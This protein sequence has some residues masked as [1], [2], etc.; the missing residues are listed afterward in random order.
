[1]LVKEDLGGP[2]NK[3]RVQFEQL[4]DFSRKPSFVSPQLRDANRAV[5]PRGKLRR[6]WDLPDA[7]GYQVAKRI[8]NASAS[9]QT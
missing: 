7:V 5:V 8:L 9:R 2:A 1:M 6:P 4:V 3:S